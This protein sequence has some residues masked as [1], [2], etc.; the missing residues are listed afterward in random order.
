MV[1]KGALPE[2]RHSHTAVVHGDKM[3]VFGGL[4]K[5]FELN[6]LW[7]F[8]FKKYRW[9]A[10]AAT[11]TPP[12]PRA[13]HTA[14]VYDGAM[15]VFGGK[16]RVFMN[17]MHRFD[18]A[19]AEW[20][21]VEYRG[22][23]AVPA[24]RSM[25]AAVVVGRFMYVLCGE[26]EGSRNLCDFYQYSF[27]S[28]C[29]HAMHASEEHL[30]ERSGHCAVVYTKFVDGALSASTGSASSAG[31]NKPRSVARSVVCAT[32]KAPAG[33]AGTT[34]TADAL[35]SSATA[36]PASPSPTAPLLLGTSR[37]GKRTGSRHD[38][39][40]PSARSCTLDTPLGRSGSPPP[41]RPPLAASTGDGKAATVSGAA[42]HGARCPVIVV[43][44]GATRGATRVDL[45]VYELETR[46][47]YTP[48]TID[49]TAVDART[50]F[51]LAV[52][53]DVVYAAG[54]ITYAADGR[55]FNKEVFCFDLSVTAFSYRGKRGAGHTHSHTASTQSDGATSMPCVPCVPSPPAK[56]ASCVSC[57]SDFGAP[58]ELRAWLRERGLESAYGALAAEE[59][60]TLAALRLLSEDDLKALRLKVGV[61][62][63]LRRELLKEQRAACAP[64]AA[65]PAPPRGLPDECT[66][67]AV[68]KVRQI[69]GGNFGTVYEGLWEGTTPVAMKKLLKQ[70][71]REFK[72]E[73]ALLKSL[74]HPN[75]VI[76]YGLYTD[77]ET[78]ERFIC[79][80]YLPLGSLD[81]FLRE[82]S[83]LSLDTLLSLAIGASAGMNYLAHHRIVHRDLAAR[84]LLVT[85]GEDN[86]FTVKVTDFGLS[87]AVSAGE[88]EASSRL[89]P[90]K[91]TAPE[92]VLYRRFTTKSDVWSFGVVLWEVFE[93]GKTPYPGM[94]NKEALD[95]VT[96]GGRMG[97]PAALADENAGRVY[98]LMC[99]CWDADPDAR[100][101]FDSVYA[102]LTDV[103]RRNAALR[104][105]R[106][107]QRQRQGC[108]GA[109]QEPREPQEHAEAQHGVGE[110]GGEA[111]RLE[112]D[113]SRQ[114]TYY[115]SVPKGRSMYYNIE[116]TRTP[117]STEQPVLEGSYDTYN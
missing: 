12:P 83:A 105:Q 66:L 76:L 73:L 67:T 87:R 42:A 60:T 10:I 14:V 93:G 88:Y 101:G 62:L 28:G 51:T 31:S 99:A 111:E 54:G 16:A 91:W 96:G 82:Y 103:R 27:R 61:R 102:T 21:E 37:R 70:D 17:D 94:T 34:G 50:G 104:E 30:G 79:T 84:N 55:G 2:P 33:T 81:K 64:C 114:E 113:G 97:K 112:S 47:W 92:A 68:A 23:G 40:A 74:R 56:T 46:R 24:P 9:E 4:S 49:D 15:Y 80:E 58:D 25:H 26:T 77:G 63:C 52:A 85:R 32:L 6:D 110:E 90:I 89:C 115:T 3:Y 7:A 106:Q 39:Q 57:A 69:G 53:D 108:C 18:F 72:N 1:V 8:D 78:G 116:H 43:F 59:V 45:A 117:D 48:V 36:L 5:D 19:R 11:G 65:S 20:S 71:D 13:E 41:S 35:A 38:A 98:G 29:W 22:G 109:A 44:G 95:F 86:V 75:C 100:P 107:Q